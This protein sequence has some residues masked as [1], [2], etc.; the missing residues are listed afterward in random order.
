MGAP[1]RAALAHPDRQ[2]AGRFPTFTV[3]KIVRKRLLRSLSACF[4][5]GMLSCPKIEQY[6]HMVKT[7][8]LER[9]FVA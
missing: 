9:R 5:G 3:D 8:G 2:D 6:Q 7:T 1:S 4:E